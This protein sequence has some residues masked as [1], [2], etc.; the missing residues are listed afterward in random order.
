MILTTMIP[1]NIGDKVKVSEVYF[2]KPFCTVSVIQN[3]DSFREVLVIDVKNNIKGNL[4]VLVEISDLTRRWIPI[5]AIRS[6]V[7]LYD[8]V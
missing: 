7:Q 1:F 6:W 4:Q 8:K 2:L 5:W 3:A